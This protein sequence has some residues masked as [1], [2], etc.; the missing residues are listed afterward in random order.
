ME[1]N[2]QWKMTFNGRHPLMEDT[3]N[4]RRLLV[5]RFRDSALPYTAVAVISNFRWQV[6]LSPIRKFD[7][8]QTMRL[9]KS[10][11]ML[12]TFQDLKILEQIEGKV[13][14]FNKV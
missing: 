6:D 2:L 14:I 10:R 8:A 7:F 3:F 1:D 11:Q 9:A 5:Q 13:L 12:I 4:G